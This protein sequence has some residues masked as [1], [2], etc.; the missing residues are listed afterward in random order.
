MPTQ[1]EWIAFSNWAKIYGDLYYINVLGHDMI[2]VNSSKVA[3]DLFEKSSS[4]YSDRGRLP[5]L[6]DLMGF[7][8]NFAFMRYGNLWRRHRKLMHKKF[9]PTAAAKYHPIQRSQ[10]RKL[11][12]QFCETPTEFVEH[13]RHTAGAIIMEIIYG[14]KVAPKNDRYIITA[15]LAMHGMTVAGNFGTF[16]VDS[17]PILKYVPAWFPGAGFKR[18]AALWRKATT[19]MSIEP[20]QAVKRAMEMGNETPSFTAS[21]LA[22]L[23]HMSNKPIGEEDIIRS[24]GSTVYLG[25]S[26]TTVSALHTFILAMVCYPEVQRKAQQEL[27]RVIGLHRLPDFGDRESLPYIE[28]I[29]KE[30]YRWH[31]VVPMG[32]GHAVTQDDIYGEFFI[33]KGSIIVGNIWHILHDEKDYGPDTHKF[34]PERF[35]RPGVK[36]PTAAFGFGRRICPGRYMADNSVFIAIASILKA[37]SI[38]PAEDINGNP[39]PIKEAFTSGFTSH[40]EDFVC[41]ITPRSEIIKRLIYAEIED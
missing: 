26:E 30:V 39:I 11:L 7:D 29:M 41:R 34:I 22:E 10:T 13:L 2:V 1:Q 31:P 12:Q 21:L 38:S 37:F 8:W 4:I 6:N 35:L 16:L 25:G 23:H 17:M 15:K 5:M 18:R 32:V 20:F 28:L 3:Y 40:P 33:P 19:D 36:E 14:I 27:D 24:T 9:H